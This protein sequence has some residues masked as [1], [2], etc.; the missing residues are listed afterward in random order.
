MS[1]TV[2]N[3]FEI[4]VCAAGH[5]LIRRGVYT[6]NVFVEN[7]ISVCRL[8]IYKTERFYEVCR[9]N[10]ASVCE[11]VVETISAI[12]GLNFYA[13]GIVAFCR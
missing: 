1:L 9:R 13:C 4:C 6:R 12:G 7:V 11:H 5:R 10:L 2:K 3:S 8:V